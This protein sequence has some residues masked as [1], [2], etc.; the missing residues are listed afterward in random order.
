MKPD[1]PYR[2]LGVDRHASTEQIRA[3][4][5]DAIRRAHPDGAGERASHETITALIDSWRLLGDPVTRA[6]LDA[7]DRSMSHGA[8]TGGQLSDSRPVDPATTMLLKRMFL[9]TTLVS[10]AFLCALFLI[11]MAESG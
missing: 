1:D 3:A 5:R 2:V 7:G 9:L 4:F 11:A 10:A 8:T 6:D